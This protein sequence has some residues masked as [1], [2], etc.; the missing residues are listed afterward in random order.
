VRTKRRRA[1]SLTT[2]AQVLTTFAF[3]LC[4]CEA[5]SAVAAC[6]T[7]ELGASAPIA[8]VDR[9]SCCCGEENGATN[10]LATLEGSAKT[11][12][13]RAFFESADSGSLAGARRAR[14]VSVLPT[15]S[16]PRPPLRI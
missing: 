2:L 15:I 4:A 11:E 3:A 10:S 8:I 14:F 1:A 16:R 5:A 6:H 7:P 13:P 12:T 9:D